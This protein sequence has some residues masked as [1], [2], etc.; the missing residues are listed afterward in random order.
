M[1]KDGAGGSVVMRATATEGLRLQRYDLRVESAMEMKWVTSDT[2][3]ACS[4]GDSDRLERWHW[5]LALVEVDAVATLLP[6][7]R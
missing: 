1:E 7:C 2:I 5:K 3:G 4:G 6:F